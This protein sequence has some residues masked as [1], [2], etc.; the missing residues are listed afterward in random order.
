MC[1]SSLFDDQELNVLRFHLSAKGHEL[2]PLTL[3]C[4]MGFNPDERA[5][6]TTQGIDDCGF[7]SD[8][9]VLQGALRRVSETALCCQRSLL[10][11]AVGDDL[12]SSI[13]N[14]D[15]V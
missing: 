3:V 10:S 2:Q 12:F 4:R 13:H 5:L 8:C 7:G 9:D 15:S 14:S 1:Q 6:F 11:E